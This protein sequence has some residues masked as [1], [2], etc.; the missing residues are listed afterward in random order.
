MRG[1]GD[2]NRVGPND[3]ALII[4]EKEEEVL[5]QIIQDGDQSLKRK[6]QI[7]SDEGGRHGLTQKGQLA[8][9]KVAYQVVG[10][11][12][13]GVTGVVMTGHLG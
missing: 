9:D 4:A 11:G 6:T 10:G 7:L 3:G 12:H 8:D 5:L 2:G 1:L 13:E